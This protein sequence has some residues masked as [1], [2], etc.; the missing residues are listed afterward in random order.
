MQAQLAAMLGGPKKHVGVV[1]LAA[2]M[3]SDQA[4][5]AMTSSEPERAGVAESGMSGAV[6]ELEGLGEKLD[7]TMPRLS[8]DRSPG[9][10]RHVRSRRT[11]RMAGRIKRAP[12]S[13]SP[14]IGRALVSAAVRQRHQTRRNVRR[15]RSRT[16]F[17]PA[18]RLRP[19]RQT[20]A[21]EEILRAFR[22]V[23]RPSGRGRPLRR[24]PH[25]GRIGAIR[26]IGII[27]VEEIDVGVIA[28]LA[29]PSGRCA[30]TANVPGGRRA[31]RRRAAGA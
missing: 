20:D 5:L 17:Q 27:N 16:G 28:H 30:I 24:S 4:G 11:R 2:E 10:P 12:R 25:A 7:R 18:I 26:V 9:R 31:R 19:G 23:T 15:I 13:A 22:P 1:E 8:G 3:F 14:A 6:P 29:S 21:I